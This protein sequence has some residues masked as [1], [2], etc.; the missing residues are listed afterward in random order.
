MEHVFARLLLNN[1]NYYACFTKT[2]LNSINL[3]KFTSMKKFT[4][5]ILTLLTCMLSANADVL[6]VWKV[7]GEKVVYDFSKKPEIT[8]VDGKICVSTLNGIDEYNPDEVRALNFNDKQ[9]VDGIGLVKTNG[10]NLTITASEYVV[11]GIK[12]GAAVCVYDASGRCILKAKADANGKAV[13][14]TQKVS[15][16]VN[17]IKAGSSTFKTMKR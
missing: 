1:N 7:S 9:L 4:I 5:T 12:A 14:P 15:A 16:G 10:T 13:I 8:Y 6:N 2:N 11:S 17:V 3:I